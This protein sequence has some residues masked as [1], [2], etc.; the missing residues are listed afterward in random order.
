MH[1]YLFRLFQCNLWYYAHLRRS[2][3]TTV[4]AIVV[5]LSWC[6]TQVEGGGSVDTQRGT[7]GAREWTVL[8]H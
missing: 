1:Q 6:S 4:F 3:H 7:A 2:Y 8:A 5:L